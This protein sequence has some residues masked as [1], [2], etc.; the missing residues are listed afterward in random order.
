MAEWIKSSLELEQEAK[1]FFL[2]SNVPFKY[3]Q[4]GYFATLN[5][6]NIL[7]R[8]PFRKST[9][10]LFLAYIASLFINFDDKGKV[11][12]IHEAYDCFGKRIEGS[13]VYIKA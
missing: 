2:Y 4:S 12:I 7:S 1:G 13:S 6:A 9:I 10:S 5:T 3:N 11:N 8:L